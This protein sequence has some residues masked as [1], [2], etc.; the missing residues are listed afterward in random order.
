MVWRLQLILSVSD[1]LITHGN[2][3]FSKFIYILSYPLCT[4]MYW[5]KL[6]LP[7]NVIKMLTRNC[8]KQSLGI[9]YIFEYLMYIFKNQMSMFGYFKIPDVILTLASSQKLNWT[10]SFDPL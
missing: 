5:T 6:M 4:C 10:H 7:I 8:W 9:M 2:H 3:L 1:R